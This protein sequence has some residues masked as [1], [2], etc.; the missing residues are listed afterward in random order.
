MF[1]TD[2]ELLTLVKLREWKKK[3]ERRE[4]IEGRLESIKAEWTE[5]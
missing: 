4:N 2:D 5:I 3:H 1:G